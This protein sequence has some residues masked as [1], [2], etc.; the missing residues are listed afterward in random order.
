MS[1][2]TRPTDLPPALG[3]TIPP[4]LHALEG[5][6]MIGLPF[7][8]GLLPARGSPGRANAST[9]Y[10]WVIEGVRMRDGRR[11]K[12]EAV[13]I[14]SSYHTSR[15][16]VGRFIRA[17]NEPTPLADEPAPPL[18]AGQRLRELRLAKERAAKAGKKLESM[19]M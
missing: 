4:K 18:T 5:E 1:K 15:E 3:Q 7:A 10:R 13:R 6:Q 19:G 17:M 2:R 8:A 9:L 16:A 11:V 14:G 12:L